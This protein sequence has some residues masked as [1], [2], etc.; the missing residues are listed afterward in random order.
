MMVL[1]A[2]QDDELQIADELAALQ[3]GCPVI[4]TARLLLRPPH[5][6]DIEDIAD[7]ANNYQVA[8]MLSSMPHPYFAAD[9][10]EFIEKVGRAA[11]HGCV[12]AITEASSGRFMGVC[13]LHEDP[14]RHALP[15]IGYWLGEPYWGR[16]YASEAARAL[17]DLF[18]KVTDRDQLLISCRVDN[19]ASRRIIEKCGARYWKSGTA[20]NRALGEMQQLDHYRVTRADWVAAAA[21]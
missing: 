18:F 5:R 4:G 1:D 6:D 16:G 9:A 17:V 11:A 2:N 12:Y 15:F 13:G 3:L 8:R 7:L 20:Y 10:Q 14:S 19:H 21:S